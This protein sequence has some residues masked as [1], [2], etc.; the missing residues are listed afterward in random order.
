MTSIYVPPQ[1]RA[2]LATENLVKATLGAVDK[3]GAAGLPVEALRT[4]YR[5][6]CVSPA[7]AQHIENRLVR[8]G[9]VVLEADRLKMGTP[10]ALR[11][12]LARS[13][14]DESRVIAVA[15]ETV[16]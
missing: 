12:Y 14:W 8:E 16:Q 7:L 9:I 15:P 11:A 5:R 2:R 1:V 3:A 13:R 6:M 10:E 4:G